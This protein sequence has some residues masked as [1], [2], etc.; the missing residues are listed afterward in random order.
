ME[1]L[2]D[3]KYMPLFVKKQDDIFEFCSVFMFVEPVQFFIIGDN[4]TLLKPIHEDLI[5]LVD[6]QLFF[7]YGGTGFH[8]L[9][10]LRK[11]N[12][13]QFYTKVLTRG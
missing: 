13:H 2:T 3:R 7:Q 12:S 9:S 5:V 8:P 1:L 4:Q 11:E 6:S 10:I